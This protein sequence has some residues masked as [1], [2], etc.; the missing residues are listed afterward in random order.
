MKR[1]TV[2]GVTLCLPFV[3]CLPGNS[4]L[5]TLAPGWL[6]SQPECLET[7]HRHPPVCCEQSLIMWRGAPLSVGPRENAAS[8]ATRAPG[9]WFSLCC[10]MQRPGG[11]ATGVRG[12][13][14]LDYDTG[15]RVKYAAGRLENIDG[16]IFRWDWQRLRCH[17]HAMSWQ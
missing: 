15:V 11:V 5:C 2:M 16:K 6:S 3:H 17:C 14:C 1:R 13:I 7:S 12:K 9:N 10:V 8:T 4:T